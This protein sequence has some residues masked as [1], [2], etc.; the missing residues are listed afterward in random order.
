M[1]RDIRPIHTETDYDEAM[2]SIEELWDNPDQESQDRLEVY[3]AG[4][5]QGAPY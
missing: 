3:Y 5:R 1:A 2:G 4:S